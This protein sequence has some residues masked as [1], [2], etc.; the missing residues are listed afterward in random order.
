[1]DRRIFIASLASLPFIASARASQNWSARFVNGGFDGASHRAGL[2]VK[3]DDGWKTYWRNPGESGIPPSIDVKGDN[4]ESFAVDFPLP[5][6]IIDESGESIGFH[7]EVLFPLHLKPK[8]IT[9]AID[10]KLSAFFG[11]CEQVCVPAKF[12]DE[13]KFPPLGDPADV[14]FVAKWQARVPKTGAIVRESQIINGHL[15]LTLEQKF[16]DVFVEGPDRF[17]FR[18]PDFKR[19]AGKAWIKI[20]GLKAP[21]DIKGA[22]LRVTAAASGQGLEQ[23]IVL[24]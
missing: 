3:L 24:A 22:D 9:Q 10:A 14:D 16:D 7:D 1:M 5:Q 21:A 4:L 23:H 15:V 20:D 11:V 17:Y 2:Y 12:A 6:R 13:L 18:K 19:E 8:D